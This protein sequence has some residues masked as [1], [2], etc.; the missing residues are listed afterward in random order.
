VTAHTPE[1]ECWEAWQNPGTMVRLDRATIGIPLLGARMI[2][3]RASGRLNS[4]RAPGLGGIVFGPVSHH[5][6]RS[7]S[8]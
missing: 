5:D 3:E 7:A 6:A 1:I 8:S 4:W 2:H